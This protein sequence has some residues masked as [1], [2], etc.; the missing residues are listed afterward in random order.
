MLPGIAPL[1]YHYRIAL[2]RPGRWSFL[3]NDD[4]NVV[5][6]VFISEF[7]GVGTQKSKV[8]SVRDLD[9]DPGMLI[10]FVAYDRY[11]LK[12]KRNIWGTIVVL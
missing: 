11:R 5:T 6:N 9:N 4:S 3:W 2:G 1:L 7:F 12:K 8:A 10:L